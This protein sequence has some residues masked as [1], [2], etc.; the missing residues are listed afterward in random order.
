MNPGLKDTANI[1]AIAGRDVH[2]ID[3]WFAIHQQ[4][5]LKIL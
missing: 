1:L 5:R 2:F 4:F 3:F